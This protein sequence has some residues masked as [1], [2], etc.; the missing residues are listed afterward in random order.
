MSL[1]VSE[2]REPKGTPTVS[3][4]MKT[5]VYKTNTILQVKNYK[6]NWR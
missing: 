6:A 1:K 5:F 2:T 4:K 3:L